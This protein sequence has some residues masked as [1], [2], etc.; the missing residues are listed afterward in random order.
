VQFDTSIKGFGIRPGD[1]ITVTYLTEG[2]NRQLFRVL[3]IS[4]ATNYRTC[5][6][7]AQIHDDAWYADTNGQSTSA[8][9]SPQ[10]GNNTVGIPRPLIGSMIDANGNIQFGIVETDSRSSDGTA[11]ASLSVSFS[12][13]GPIAQSGTA[14]GVPLLNLVATTGTGGTLTGGQTLY[15][16]VSALDSQGNESAL[17]FM[18]QALVPQDDSS[19]TLTGLSFAAGTSG[20][21]VYRGVTPANMMQIASNQPVSGTFTDAGL[22]CELLGPPDVNFDHANFYWRMELVPE[23]EVTIYSTITVG[24]GTLQMGMNAYQGMT[25]RITKGAGAGQERIVASNDPTSI[26]VS[27]PWTVEPDPTSSF[28]VAEAAWHFAALTQSS[29][30]QF[31]VPNLAGEVVQVTGRSANVNNVECSAAL[32]LVTRWQIGGSGTSDTD[33]PGMPF[34]GLSQ[35]QGEGTVE[36]SGLAFADLKNTQ[37]VTSATLT[38][39]YWN[40]LLG[41]AATGLAGAV[42][43]SDTTL[44]LNTPGTCLPGTILQVDRELMQVTAVASSGTQYTV[45]RAIQGTTA[46]AHGLGMPV[47]QLTA[48]TVI[49]PFPDRFFGSPYCGSWSYTIV[50]PNVR[51][52]S[53][54]LFATNQIGNSPTATTLLTH[55][56][57][58]GLRT[59]SGGQY[60]IQVDGFLA[61][62]QSVAPALVVEA[63]HSVM[64]VYAIMGTAADATVQLQL[65]LNGALYC[66]LTFAAGATLSSSVDGNTLPPLTAGAQL[67]LS[68]LSVGQVLPGGDLTVLVRL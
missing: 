23:I 28:A 52:A 66:Q 56:T 4:P 29:P 1:L 50:L 26:T 57:D 24:N 55:S 54:Q 46:G 49:V 68:V 31:V 18:V 21:T 3:K 40:E 59:L 15:Y 45:V 53:G 32:S 14:P 43:T 25:A 17:S 34:F 20:F 51:V 16:A 2:F 22:S 47:Y 60:S 35:G 27:T 44:T 58:S 7:T 41:T 5:T 64:D 38:L 48:M 63:A 6:I 39:Y 42:G 8:W 12:V 65:N 36:L 61:V 37:T 33:V 13:P 19:V 62:D 11:E 30:M 67:T 9:G 10:P